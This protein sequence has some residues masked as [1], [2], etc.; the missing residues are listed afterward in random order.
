[1]AIVSCH[2]RVVSCHSRVGGNLDSPRQKSK[3]TTSAM[4]KQKGCHSCV[5]RNL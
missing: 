1:M 2:S 4:F 5:G 3:D